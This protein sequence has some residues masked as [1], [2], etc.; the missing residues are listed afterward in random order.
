MTLNQLRIIVA[1]VDAGF[2][3]THA[4]DRVHATQPGLSKQLKQIEEYLGVSLFVRKGKS[5]QGLTPAGEAILVHARRILAEVR[6]IRTVAANLKQ[7]Q[8]GSLR[9]AT[10]YTQAR[11]VLPPVAAELR[12]RLPDVSIDIETGEHDEAIARLTRGDVDVAVFS[13]SG[14]APEGVFAIPAYHWHRV[15]LVPKDH[16]LAEL[17]RLI[18]HADLAEYPLISYR[19]SR[20][21]T[22]S[23][24]HAFADHGITPNVAFTARDADVIKAHVRARLGVGLIAGIAVEAVDADDLAVLDVSALFPRC[25]TW[26]ALRRNDVVPHFVAEFISLYAP[27]ITR[28]LLKE[29]RERPALIDSLSVPVWSSSPLPGQVALAA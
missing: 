16:P 1:I 29:L 21:P 9:V 22:S 18:T 3:I 19:S 17:K 13:T 8:V 6:Q 28:S 20:L 25:T 11:Y 24:L 5:M 15:A 7:S 23:L 26:I 10:V 27:R 14:A 4:A 2:N 12:K